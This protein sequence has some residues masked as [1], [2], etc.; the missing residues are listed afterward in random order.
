MLEASS[1]SI[2]EVR[3]AQALSQEAFA[4]LLGVSVRTIA[5]WESG[6]SRPS[7]LAIERLQQTVLQQ[8]ERF[9]SHVNRS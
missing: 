9:A 1:I 3:E 5:R 7:P 8:N 6:E 4:R 2:R